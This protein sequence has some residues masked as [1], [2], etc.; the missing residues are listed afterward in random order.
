MSLAAALAFLEGLWRATRSAHPMQ[1]W[2]VERWLRDHRSTIVQFREFLAR[3]KAVPHFVGVR[4]THD[5]HQTH[6]ACRAPD[7]TER[8][9]EHIASE[10]KVHFNRRRH[11][12]RL[13]MSKNT[14]TAWFMN[15]P[16]VIK[17]G[18]GK[19]TKARRHTYVPLRIPQ[20]VARRVYARYTGKDY[21][22]K[23]N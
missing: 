7:A 23:G 18:A 6:T 2:R 20:S 11:T 10:L 8:R 12:H 17:F 16:G 5:T 3:E 14:L 1:V 9:P 13:A 15:E 21:P 22:A 4:K 19:L